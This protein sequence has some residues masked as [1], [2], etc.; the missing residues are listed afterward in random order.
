MDEKYTL[1]E[2]AKSFLRCDYNNA[3]VS[4][5]FLFEHYSNTR[6]RIL[7]ILKSYERRMANTHYAE[8]GLKSDYEVPTFIQ[9][10]NSQEMSRKFFEEEFPLMEESGVLKELDD[11]VSEINIRLRHIASLN[12]GKKTSIEAAATRIAKKPTTEKFLEEIRGL[13]FQLIQKTKEIS[14]PTPGAKSWL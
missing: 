11:I 7:A 8:I 6:E 13:L 5:E 14:T 12:K 4:L 10:E 1:S 2:P 3:W 9:K